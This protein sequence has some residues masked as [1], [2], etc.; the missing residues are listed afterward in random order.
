MPEGNRFENQHLY[1]D[2][3]LG[4]FSEAPPSPPQ[5]VPIQQPPLE[6]ER[7][8][9]D[10]G[11]GHAQDV[12]RNEPR[13]FAID[14]PRRF[15]QWENTRP[16][17]NPRPI[18]HDHGRVPAAAVVGAREW[19]NPVNLVVAWVPVKSIVGKDMDDLTEMGVAHVFIVLAL[20]VLIT[21]VLFLFIR[22]YWMNR[23]GYRGNIRK[24]TNQYWT[25]SK[26]FA[27]NKKRSDS[28]NLHLRV[29]D[30]CAKNKKNVKARNV[31]KKE[32]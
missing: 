26:M 18:V 12:N 19:W 9:H 15:G 2:F 11:S 20:I 13:G 24:L 17:P 30:P 4:S 8:K 25:S 1:R 29:K 5:P 27:R 16:G 21:I 6:N 32:Y 14:Q 22:S 7:I 10:G 28:D 23:K 31:K 3:D